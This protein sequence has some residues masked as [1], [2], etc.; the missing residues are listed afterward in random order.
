VFIS[1]TMPKD[2]FEIEVTDVTDIEKPKEVKLEK[3]K[4]VEKSCICTGAR[5]PSCPTHK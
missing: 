4:P 3:A 1:L 2:D 5:H